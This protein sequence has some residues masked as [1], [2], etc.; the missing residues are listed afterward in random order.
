MKGTKK[1][2]ITELFVQPRNL[3]QTHQ[4]TLTLWLLELATIL[5]EPANVLR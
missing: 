4:N 1:C 2:Q 5:T 3:R